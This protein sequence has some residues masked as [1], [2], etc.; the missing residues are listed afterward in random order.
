MDRPT[1]EAGMDSFSGPLWGT[2][3]KP[4]THGWREGSGRPI[5]ETS[6]HSPDSPYVWDEIRT[7]R[8]PLI[9]RPVR[10]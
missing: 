2:A 6:C 1:G 10:S 3:V 9:V 5:I 4:Q 7:R 8:H